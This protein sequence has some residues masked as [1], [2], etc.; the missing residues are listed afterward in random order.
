LKLA[1]VA[2]TDIHYITNT[3]YRLSDQNIRPMTIVLAREKT[4]EAIK[5][6]FLKR[7]TIA[8]FRGMLAGS[9]D[10]LKDFFFASVSVKK[11]HSYKNRDHKEFIYY[12]ISNP[13]DV[14]YVFFFNGR[15]MTLHANSEITFELPA[16]IKE[17]KANII[18]L[19]TYENETLKVSI[20][21]PQ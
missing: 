12:Q 20:S 21:L 6:A 7:N 1:P 2:T 17:L 3:F 5:D 19:H 9:S 18:N 4:Q 13:Y 16:E 15:K 14:P 8:F 10:L 11:I